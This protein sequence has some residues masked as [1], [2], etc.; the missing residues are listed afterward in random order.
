MKLNEKGQGIMEYI[1]ITTFVGLFCLVA[2]K[3]FG[4]VVEKR[5]EVMKNKIVETM[6]T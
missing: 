5:I 4:E 2:M 3:K 6:P 1:I